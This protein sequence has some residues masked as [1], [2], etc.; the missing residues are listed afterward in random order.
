M[1]R[2]R[3]A[4]AESSPCSARSTPIRV[5]TRNTNAARGINLSTAQDG[6]EVVVFVARGTPSLDPVHLNILEQ[7][8]KDYSSGC[9]ARAKGEAGSGKSTTP[10]R[11]SRS[12]KARDGKLAAADRKREARA[13]VAFEKDGLRFVEIVSKICASRKASIPHTVV[14]KLLKIVENH[15]SHR[16]LPL[17]SHEAYLCLGRVH[18]HFP[19]TRFIETRSS[20]VSQRTQVAVDQKAWTPLCLDRSLDDAD[21]MM[22]AAD[23]DSSEDEDEGG[24]G[25]G[26]AF[27]SRSR[28]NS[29]RGRGRATAWQEYTQKVENLQAMFERIHRDG[30]I[31]C[32]DFASRAG[33]VLA[34][35]HF[36]N[37]LLDDLSARIEV[38]RRWRSG[39]DKRGAPASNGAGAGAGDGAGDEDGGES[40][41][42]QTKKQKY[43]QE[44]SKRKKEREVTASQ[45]DH[46]LRSSFL[47]HLSSLTHKTVDGG[48]NNISLKS[49]VHKLV[50]LRIESAASIRGRSEPFAEAREEGEGKMERAGAETL[51]LQAQGQMVAVCREIF[52]VCG[53]VFNA[54]CALFSEIEAAAALQPLDR[55]SQFGPNER[56]EVDTWVVEAFFNRHVT[57]TTRDKNLVLQ[58]FAS[59]RHKL[60]FLGELVAQYLGKSKNVP[61]S[62]F[63]LHEAVK[64]KDS[65][66]Q[67][68]LVDED[69]I[70]EFVRMHPRAA[71]VS[72]ES[73]DNVVLLIV[74]I[75]QAKL[76]VR[77]GAERKGHGEV[78]G[79][80]GALLGQFHKVV[81]AVKGQFSGVRSDKDLGGVG[82]ILGNTWQPSK[83][84]LAQLAVCQGVLAQ[85]AAA[86]G[87]GT[88]R[89]G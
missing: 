33:V 65:L 14:E 18:A 46:L 85:A 63:T 6:Q 60:R 16:H 44:V 28:L 32:A 7:Y 74:H 37:V 52:L 13:S 88:P 50:R 45:V 21:E 56:K 19:P 57:K 80:C 24:G 86:A 49:F 22:D 4:S 27:I 8:W 20:E 54:I 79:E 15:A 48:N 5:G 31:D 75:F 72:L 41:G 42:A 62:L 38:S 40:S 71:V 39:K 64:Y 87:E 23:S 82:R 26:S 59:S 68:W 3:G 25:N 10:G 17:L 83:F 89:G 35:K 73:V 11:P 9:S 30:E 69:E 66:S 78:R 67:S 61:E 76:W 51:A 81:E 1:F 47:C 58:M 34:F 29:R 2:R 36:S 53:K 77:R 84:A 43:D 12:Q 70:V 55:Q